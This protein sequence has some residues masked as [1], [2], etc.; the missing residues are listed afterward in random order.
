[1]RWPKKG[2]FLPGN[3]LTVG[4]DGKVFDGHSVVL[5][6]YEDRA[7]QAGGG[8]LIFRNSSGPKWREAGHARLTYEYVRTYCNDVL[9]LRVGT[10]D[11]MPSNT[12]AASPIEIEAL[13]V[14]KATDCEHS[15]Q[16]MSHWGPQLWSGGKQVFGRGKPGAELA[17]AFPVE[18]AGRFRLDVYATRAPDY[19][20][21]EVKVDGRKTGKQIDTYAEDVEPTGR[22]SLGTMNLDAGQ[23]GL[24]FRVV[25]KNRK[26]TGHCFGI[27]CIELTKPAG[28]K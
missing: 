10:G 12:E 21:I 4:E 11:L 5:V 9:G 7:E 2:R 22:I 18:K 23:H 3:V 27:D 6:G 13:E 20:R 1:M 25:G 14:V 15:T 24:S 26:S 28:K 8:T 19:A 17:F 16:R